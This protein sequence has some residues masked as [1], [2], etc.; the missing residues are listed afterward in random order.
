M[1]RVNVI[2]IDVCAVR[3]SGI[4]SG[5]AVLNIFQINVT[6]QF[7]MKLFLHITNL[8]TKMSKYSIREPFPF[9]G[10]YQRLGGNHIFILSKRKWR[11]R[12]HFS[13]KPKNARNCQLLLSSETGFLTEMFSSF[14]HCKHPLKITK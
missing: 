14:Y 11:W 6:K 5:Y 9:A 13:L 12:K 2:F 10:G 8:V 1:K 3:N 4:K 7:Y